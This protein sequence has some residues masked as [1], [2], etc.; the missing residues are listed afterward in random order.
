MK[1]SIELYDYD[2]PDNLI[3][4]T[5]PLK[6][7]SSKLMV[8]DKT[9]DTVEHTA[10]SD[11]YNFLNPGDLLVLNDT[12]VI[13]GRLFVKKESGGAVELLFHKTLTS[14]EAI[15]IFGTSG[16]LKTGAILN[17]NQKYY[18]TVTNIERN[19]VTIKSEDNI[20]NLFIK[21]GEIPL[22]KYIKRKANKDDV[23]RY[24]TTYAIN[25]G[26]VAA[27]TAGLHFTKEVL[28][29]LKDKGVILEYLTLHVTYNTFK[30]VTNDNYLLHDIGSEYCEV[31]KST[32]DI[33]KNAKRKNKRVIAVGTTATRALENYATKLYKSNYKGEADLF[34]TPGYKFKLINGL[35]TNFH[36]PK[37]TLLLLVASL[38]GRDKLL[39]LYKK[40]IDKNYKFYS[41]GDSMLLKI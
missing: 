37:S 10:F 28:N 18:L 33:I 9:Y 19:Y 13:P 1:T 30:P 32:I 27:P 31:K 23:D 36:L 21:Y 15:C 41:Y 38:I 24:Q 2:L 22:P 35:I 11:I 7:D 14:K 20:M 6:R 16:K 29:K 40:A 5:P 34:I 39:E 3:A 12:K 26:S 8:F 4:F 25:D 17:F